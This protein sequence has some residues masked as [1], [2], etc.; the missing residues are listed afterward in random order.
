MT[1]KLR[2]RSP[3][4]HDKA[5]LAFIRLQPCCVCGRVQHIEAAHIRMSCLALGKEY[6]GK[7]EKPDDN[8]TV[9]LCAYHHRIGIA[10][11]HNV[12]EEEF[13]KMHGRD[14]FAIALK[15]W[16]QS[17]GE[18]R[19]KIP[20]PIK[21]RKIKARKPPE[22]RKRIQRGRKLTSNPVIPSRPFNRTRFRARQKRETV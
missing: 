20:A 4:H 21:V 11:Q 9:P 3:R 16:A 5:H 15:Y 22:R 1:P 17:G 7:A 12:G 19:A 18:E 10:S 14:P 8:W 2:Q 13:W 6:T